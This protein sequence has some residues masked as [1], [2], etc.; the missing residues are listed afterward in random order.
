MMKINHVE[1]NSHSQGISSVPVLW[2][3]Q[4]G[5]L[6]GEGTGLLCQSSGVWITTFVML[7]DKGVGKAKADIQ[8]TS[9]QNLL[10]QYYKLENC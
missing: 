6:S 10:D 4:Y 3:Y 1:A 2:F 8:V 5:R 7:Q 9:T